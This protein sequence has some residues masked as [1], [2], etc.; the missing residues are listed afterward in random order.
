MVVHQ[1]LPKHQAGAELYTYYLSKELIKR[2]EVYLFYA[3]RDCK[4]EDYSLRRGFLDGIPFLEVTN[5]NT[6]LKNSYSN[7]HIDKVFEDLVEEFKPDIIHFQHLLN[8]SVNLVTIANKKGIPSVMTLHEYWLM[9]PRWGQRLKKDLTQCHD[10]IL[11]ECAE[12]MKDLFFINH[13]NGTLDKIFNF[14]GKKK[15]LRK[16]SRLLSRIILRMRDPGAYGRSSRE[17]MGHIKDILS[18]VDL[19]MAPSPSLRKEFI[20][21]GI[22]EEKIIFSD[23]GM[24][25]GPYGDICRK[26]SESIRFSFIGSPLP[27]KGV[28]LLVEAFNGIKDSRAELNIYG[29]MSLHSR[30]S[31]KLLRMARHPNIHFKGRVANNQ[32]AEI[33]AKTDVLVVPSVWFEN[34]PLTIHEAFMA[35]IPVI[36]SNLG[37]MADLV[38]HGVN[39]LLFEVGNANDLRDKINSIINDRGL[40]E[41]LKKG[42]PDIKTIEEDAREM[43]VLYQR[44]LTGAM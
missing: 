32:I 38:Q 1:F 19:F 6:E 20:K 17:R 2:N 3:D 16:I 11:T 4:K 43:E 14:T 12:C 33:L 37:G 23:Y 18:E 42:I 28:H 36:T 44:L 15:G 22:P 30:Y 5:N 25:R 21:F 39:G 35:G 34:S 13:N 26:E 9:C 8:L 29:D 41:K 7:P 31:N 27:H 24:N 40:I 10:V